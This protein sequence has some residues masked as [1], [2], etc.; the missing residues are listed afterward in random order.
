M[1]PLTL[2]AYLMGR[3]KLYSEDY[4]LDVRANAENLIKRV[5]NLFI[6]LKHP[7][8]EVTSGWRP[9]AINAKVG[10][11]KKSL[12]MMGRAVDLA[13]SEGTTK[14]LIAEHPSLLRDFGLWMEDPDSTPGWCH[15]DCGIRSERLIR[16]F[17]P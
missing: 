7:V 12:H 4:T 11:S 14:I 13:D 1:T 8:P 6:A 2:K 3:H 15:L 10:G 5:N 9:A 17:K 16:I